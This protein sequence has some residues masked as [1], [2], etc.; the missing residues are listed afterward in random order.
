MSAVWAAVES[1]SWGPLLVAIGAATAAVIIYYYVN[2][3]DEEE[4]TENTEDTTG[5]VVFAENSNMKLRVRV[6][7]QTSRV[8]LEGPEPTLT[9]L[10]TQVKEVV[11]PSAGLSTDTEFTLSLNGKE[12]LVDTGQTLASCGVVSGDMISVILP[13]SYSSYSSASPSSH[14]THTILAVPQNKPQSASGS[15]TYQSGASSS[16]ESPERTCAPETEETDMDRGEAEEEAMGIFIPEPMLCC[17][18]EEGKV[19]HSL[20]TLYQTAQCNSAS[21]CLL[22]AAHVLLL[23]TGF[24]PQGCDVRAGE[25]PSGWR[26]IGGLYRL[27]YSHPLCE[28]SLVQVVAVLMGQTLVINATL[29]T[30]GAEEISQKLALKPDAYVTQE[31]AGG[32]AGLAYRELQKLSR[33]FKDHLAY[34]LITTARE[35]LGLPALFGLPVLPP[36]L[37]LRI[38]RLLDVPSILKLSEVCRRLHSVS[39]DASLWKHFVYRDFGAG[40]EQRDTDWKELYKKKFQQKKTRHAYRVRRY[41]FQVPPIYRHHPVPIPHLP[42]PLFPPGIIGG[43]HD[44]RPA[45]PQAILPRPRYDPI[46]PFIDHEPPIGL[47]FGRPLQKPGGSRAPDTRRGFI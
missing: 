25:M 3:D 31:W 15:C 36:E 8:E 28:N 22:L 26:A 46:A 40:T 45:F 18:A 10:S 33:V 43:E 37:L 13:H 17:E 7:E 1:L 21:D 11:L 23:E 32:N 5:P 47:P 42:L 2:R 9:Q 30:T 38:M 14:Q 16:H 44:L 34:P 39:Q 19:P 24:L 35:V 29:K 12:P 4:M 27:Q 41:P 20:E 6:N